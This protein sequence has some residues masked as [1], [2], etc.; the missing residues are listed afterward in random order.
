M[1]DRSNGGKEGSKRWFKWRRKYL[2]WNVGI[3]ADLNE[4][5]VISNQ[6]RNDDRCNEE[7]W[8][9]DTKTNFDSESEDSFNG[10]NGE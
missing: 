5:A 10:S 7:R 6:M 4:E 3:V 9:L 2:G 1:N 8:L